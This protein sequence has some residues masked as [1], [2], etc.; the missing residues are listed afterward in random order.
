[1][2]PRNTKTLEELRK[3]A[4]DATLLKKIANIERRKA[5]LQQ[6]CRSDDETHGDAKLSE[7]QQKDCRAFRNA[8]RLGISFDDKNSSKEVML[9]SIQEVFISEIEEFLQN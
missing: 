9:N 5:F 8:I 1:L 3:E 7:N 6:C 4:E 2:P